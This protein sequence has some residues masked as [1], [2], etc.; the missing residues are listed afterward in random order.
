MS[1]LDK[2]KLRL[3]ILNGLTATGITASILFGLHLSFWPNVALLLVPIITFCA[4]LL[5]PDP[6]DE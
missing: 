1:Q 2:L 6:A 5:L 4:G 3:L